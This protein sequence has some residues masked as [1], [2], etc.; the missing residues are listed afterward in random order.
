MVKRYTPGFK[1][2]TRPV[3]T[4]FDRPFNET[5]TVS[6][7]KG[8]P[9]VYI[10]A[11]AHGKMYALVQECPI[12]ISWL[13][14]V[15]RDE[16]GDFVIHDVYVPLQTCSGTTTNISQEGE[17]EMLMELVDAGRPQE[18]NRL[19]CWGHSHVNMGVN[20]SGVDENQ[21][22]DFLDRFDDHFI[23]VIGNKRGELMCHVYMVKEGM[24][25]NNPPIIVNEDGVDYTDW[26]KAEIDAKVGRY[27]YVAKPIPGMLKPYGSGVITDND[28]EGVLEIMQTYDHDA[29]HFHEDD[30]FACHREPTDEE[31]DNPYA[32]FGVF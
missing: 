18:I 10:T 4:K 21:T 1:L 16:D 22:Q 12:E 2:P 9:S 15:T 24:I 3:R 5:F 8:L 25:L 28:D 19:K 14:S 30:E 20:P 7:M 31:R 26:A 29:S 23:R 27:T 11:V 17:S 32:L 13:S 6:G